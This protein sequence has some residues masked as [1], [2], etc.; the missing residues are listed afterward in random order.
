MFALST[1]LRRLASR[2]SQVE[3]FLQ[4]LPPEL[5]AG[6]PQPQPLVGGGVRYYGG[7]GGGDVEGEGEEER[8]KVDGMSDTEEA[9]VNLEATAFGGQAYGSGHFRPVDSLPFFGE[10]HT[11]G[12][13]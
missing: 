1:D 3:T 2:L 11:W 7:C 4:T 8:S 12:V 9:A 6:A 10:F 13:F 5:S